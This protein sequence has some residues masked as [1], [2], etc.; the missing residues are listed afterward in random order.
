MW[1]NPD[2][3]GNMALIAQGAITFRHPH[4]LALAKMKASWETPAYEQLSLF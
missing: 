2:I 1:E 3:P 4:E